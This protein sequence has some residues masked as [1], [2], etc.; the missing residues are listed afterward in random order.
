MRLPRWGRVAVGGGAVP[1]LVFHEEGRG[2]EPIRRFLIDFVARDNRPGSVRSYA[3]DLLRWWRWLRVVQVEWTGPRPPRSATSCCGCGS[4][5]NLGRRRGRTRQRPAGQPGAAGPERETPPACPSQP[6]GS[7]RQRGPT[8]LQPQGPTPAPT[9]AARW[10]P[11]SGAG[12]DRKDA[13]GNFAGLA[14]RVAPAFQGPRHARSVRAFGCPPAPG[15]EP[16]VAGCRPCPRGPT[17]SSPLWS[18]VICAR[19]RAREPT[20]STGE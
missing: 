6:A 8:A 3:F 15:A 19:P 10:R 16:A 14:D 11:P 18:R 17:W 4:R 7:L 12:E 5:R 9:V 1:W 13:A 20:G 2:V